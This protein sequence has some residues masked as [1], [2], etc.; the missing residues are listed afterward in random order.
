MNRRLLLT[1]AALTPAAVAATDPEDK[2][3]ID[4]H[5]ATIKVLLATVNMLTERVI[6]LEKKVGLKSA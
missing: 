4:S 3:I 6:A 1:G 2:Q 5:Q